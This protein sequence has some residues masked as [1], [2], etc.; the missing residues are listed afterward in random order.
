[1]RIVCWQTILMIYHTLFLLKI[2][3]NVAKFVVCCSRDWRFNGMQPRQYF[4]SWK[5][6]LFIAYI[7]VHFRLDFIMEQTL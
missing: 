7:Q 1:M 5:R 4:L 2:R 6:L 3:E